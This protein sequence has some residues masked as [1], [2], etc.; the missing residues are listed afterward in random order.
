MESVTRH[1]GTGRET[2]RLRLLFLVPL[3]VAIV[4]IV[5]ALMLAL[6]LHKQRSVDEGV[7]KIRTSAR[8]FYED[9]IRYDARAL[10]SVMD[11]LKRDAELNAALKQKDRQRLL[12]HAAPLFADLREHFSITHFYFSD[13]ERINLLR[14]HTPLRNGDRI[15][16]HTTRS[17]AQ[18][19]SAA[20]GVE[21]GPLGTFTLRLVN[22]WFDR[23]SQEL[24]GYVELG[25]EIDRVLQK[26]RDFFGVDVFVLIHKDALDRQQWEEGMRALG[27]TPDWERF[28]TMVL[29]SHTPHAMPRILADHL[30]QDGLP[31]ASLIMEAASGGASY[32]IAFLPL[33]T[34]E[35]KAVAHMVLLTDV[36]RELD[37]AFSAVYLGGATALVAGLALFALFYWQVGRIGRGIELD[38][39][40]LER[41]AT[42]D[43]LTGLYN[44]RTFASLLEDEINH[45]RRINHAVSLLMIDVDHFKKINDAHGHQVGDVILQGVS[46]RLQAEL[47]SIDRLC[48]YGGEE[49]TAILPQLDSSALIVAERLRRAVADRPFDAGDGRQLDVTVSI[50]AASLPNDAANAEDLVFAADTALYAAKQ[51]GRNCVQA[52]D[53]AAR[54]NRGAG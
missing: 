34:V 35:G 40:E 52:A 39:A 3:G 51:A 1:S 53:A 45:G 5:M 43:A 6:L 19:G 22:P 50:G 31:N 24:L 15:D 8:D 9:S 30:A 2:R 29:S 32:R 16:R 47:R 18:S 36:S 41:L 28:S 13:P 17:A 20:Y 44:R 49:I 23:D 46:A 27:R 54:R 42:H 4:A 12:R 11:A 33:Q 48:R 38:K 37:A 25:M 14:V 10:Q 7:L 26:L 21:L